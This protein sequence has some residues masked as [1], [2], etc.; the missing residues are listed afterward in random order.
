MAQRNFSYINKAVDTI[1]GTKNNDEAEKALKD[2]VPQYDPRDTT[3][4]SQYDTKFKENHSDKPLSTHINY[5]LDKEEKRVVKD[6]AFNPPSRCCVP[7]DDDCIPTPEAPFVRPTAEPEESTHCC[8]P[9]DSR[10]PTITTGHY[11]NEARDTK[12]NEYFNREHEVEGEPLTENNYVSQPNTNE[13]SNS[14]S[15]GS[16]NGTAVIDGSITPSENTPEEPLP[17]RSGTEEERGE[18]G[19]EERDDN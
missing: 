6:Y 17:T 12:A 7:C 15:V 16:N 19:E 1:Y 11:A 13:E 14:N 4:S 5:C 9:C 3:L 18:G 2:E 10:I 8:V